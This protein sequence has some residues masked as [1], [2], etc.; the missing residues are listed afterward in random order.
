ML[1][2]LNHLIVS[3]GTNMSNMLGLW[4]RHSPTPCGSSVCMLGS[5]GA[6]MLML[7]HAGVRA[8]RRDAR[9]RMFHVKRLC[10]SKNS[11]LIHKYISRTLLVN[12]GRT[13]WGR[14]HRMLPRG[15]LP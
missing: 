3:R 14:V 15:L 7:G 12:L 8:P 6:Y 5:F 11:A 13:R 10:D 4:L 1:K 9:Y 2:V